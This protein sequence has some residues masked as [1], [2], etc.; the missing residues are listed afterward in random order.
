M[1]YD[2]FL[3][4]AKKTTKFRFRLGISKLTGSCIVSGIAEACKLR[5]DRR[6]LTE[7]VYIEV[8]RELYRDCF[9]DALEINEYDEYPDE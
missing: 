7:D 8:C 1:E 5:K 3:K 4:I 9:A 6:K 2:R